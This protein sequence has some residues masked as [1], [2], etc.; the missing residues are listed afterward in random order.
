M[1]KILISFLRHDENANEINLGRHFKA[2]N[3]FCSKV[4]VMPEELFNRCRE[5]HYVRLRS[6]FCY[7]CEMNCSELAELFKMDHT[8]IL[9]YYDTHK[10]RLMYD[11]QYQKLFTKAFI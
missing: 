8:S 5:Q 3:E 11:K 6:L 4:D 7:W 10:D 9:H 2:V 1:S